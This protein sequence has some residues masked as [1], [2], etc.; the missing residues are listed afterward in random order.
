MLKFLII[1]LLVSIGWHLG[2]L[3]FDEFANIVMSRLVELKWYR[4]LTKRP[5]KDEE[6][7]RE[8]RIGF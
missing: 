5:I 8:I 1:G 4:K 3:I 6:H 7:K 2:S